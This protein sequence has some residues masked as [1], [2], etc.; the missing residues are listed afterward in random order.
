MPTGNERSIPGSRT[1]DLDF[2]LASPNLSIAD[3][4]HIRPLQLYKVG[5][6]NRT[7]IEVQ[8]LLPGQRRRVKRRVSRG[9][10]G[11]T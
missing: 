5:W 10:V 11:Q 8:H 7:A 2:L 4:P 6:H 1:S 9:K 3:L